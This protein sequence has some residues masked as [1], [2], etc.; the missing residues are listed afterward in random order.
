MFRAP[1]HGREKGERAHMESIVMD[2]IA[3]GVRPSVDDLAMTL[4]CLFFGPYASPRTSISSTK[5][6]AQPELF[7]AE[8]EKLI[9]SFANLGS[10]APKHANS[11]CGACGASA[12][13]NGSAL[14]TCS[15]CK[16]RHYCSAQC[17]KEE[18]KDHKNMCA[19]PKKIEPN[20]TWLQIR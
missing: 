3:L 15:E 4:A 18:W 13:P 5:A 19:P 20:A 10:K 16:K 9:A 1:D 7:R 11:V 8:A 6:D 2:T 12:K 17:Q 14:L